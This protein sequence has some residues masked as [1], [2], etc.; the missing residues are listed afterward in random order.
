MTLAVNRKAIRSLRVG[1]VP[2]SHVLNLTVGIDPHHETLDKEFR[3]LKKGFSRPFVIRGEWGGGKTNLLCYI[4]E[5]ALKQKV[6]VAYIN[7]NGRSAAINHPQKLYHR[8]VADIRLPGLEDNG[9]TRLLGSIKKDSS[10]ERKTSEWVSLLGHHSELAQALGLFI[11]EDINKDYYWSFKVI[12]GSDLY[13]AEY[14]Y[15]KVKAIKR[16]N[17]LGGYLK[18][19][20]YAG[21]MIQFDELESVVQLWNIVSRRSAYKTL[22]H[23]TSLENVWTVFATTK[24]LNSQIDADVKSGR[25]RTAEAESFISRYSDFP[26]LEPPFLS[27][28]Y[29]NTLLS[30]ILKLYKEAYVVSQEIR[31]QEVLDLWNKMP[32]GNPRRLIRLAIDHLDRHRMEAKGKEPLTLQQC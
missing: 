15:K 27:Q 12:L 10:L 31:L 21:L 25:I 3:R 5:Y 2:S 14:N 26:E 28:V 22:H 23:L 29:A 18:H 16:L 30:R 19:L 6:A 4:R 24:K 11:N 7:L 9:I 1:I 17:D 8:I 32:F 13:W 20:G